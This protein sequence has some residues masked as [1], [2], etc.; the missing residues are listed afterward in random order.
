MERHPH[1]VEAVSAVVSSPR[2][3]TPA[4]CTGV[5]PQS[6]EPPMFIVEW[7]SNLVDRSPQRHARYPVQRLRPRTRSKSWDR[8]RQVVLLVDRDP[9]VDD[10]PTRFARKNSGP[11]RNPARRLRG[12]AR[13][14]EMS[15]RGSATGEPSMTEYV[16]KRVGRRGPLHEDVRHPVFSR[17]SAAATGHRRAWRSLWALRTSL[18][19]H[20]E[21]REPERLLV[22]GTEG[23]QANVQI[24]LRLVVPAPLR[25][26]KDEA[27]LL[28]LSDE[29]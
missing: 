11:D 29:G 26:R 6:S 1:V 12:R 20:R 27:A 21:Q 13:E 14:A 24:A 17:R 3:S 4:V 16:A 18:A 8:N 2:F 22:L 19:L 28:G 7:I 5:L 15:P 10:R 23:P 9:R 25:T